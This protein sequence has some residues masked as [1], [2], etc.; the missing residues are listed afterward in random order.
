[1]LLSLL[2]SL[3]LLLLLTLLLLLPLLSLLLSLLV[4]L[5]SLLSIIIIELTHST[6]ILDNTVEIEPQPVTLDFKNLFQYSS[7]SSKTDI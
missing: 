5:F 1:M 7:R 2:L 6:T 3:V 4:L